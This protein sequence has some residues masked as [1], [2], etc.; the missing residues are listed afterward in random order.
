MINMCKEKNLL[1]DNLVNKIKEINLEIVDIS[2]IWMKIEN[3]K[4]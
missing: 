1:L 4:I 3:N 2:K